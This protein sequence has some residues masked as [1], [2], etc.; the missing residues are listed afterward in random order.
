MKSKI[1]LLILFIA[2]LT[3][4]CASMFHGGPSW[5]DIEAKPANVQ[6][7]IYGL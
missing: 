4:G 7:K 6:I 2:I 3:T 5:L 1:K